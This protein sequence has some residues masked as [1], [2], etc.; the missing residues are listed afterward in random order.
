MTE[1]D[2]EKSKTQKIAPFC[3]FFANRCNKQSVNHQTPKSMTEQ[4][5]DEVVNAFRDAAVRALKAGFDMVEVHGAHG[6]LSHQFLSPI[7]N[8]V[9]F[10][11]FF[12][13]FV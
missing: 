2:I 8:Q 10:S 1:K 5:I 12:Y 9:F 11:S 13:H 3:Q 4:D 7:T 6:Y